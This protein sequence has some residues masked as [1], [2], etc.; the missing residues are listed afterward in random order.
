MI[1]NIVF[2][3]LIAAI[4]GVSYKIIT[5]PSLN[6]TTNA[7]VQGP[8]AVKQKVPVVLYG[9]DTCRYCVMAKDFLTQKGVEFQMRDVTIGA[10]R[11]EMMQRT[12]NAKTVPQIFINRQHIGGYKSLMDLEASGDLNK[13]LM[14]L[15]VSKTK[16]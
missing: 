6:E 10:N 2:I 15:S 1:R 7:M 13:I 14:G 3:V 8:T 11:N 12:T 4:A 5:D 9:R 16:S